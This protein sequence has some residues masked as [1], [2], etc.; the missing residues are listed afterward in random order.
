MN[1]TTRTMRWL[2]VCAAMWLAAESAYARGNAPPA[3]PA[4]K[5]RHENARKARTPEQVREA[6]HRRM[7]LIQDETKEQKAA[8]EAFEKRMKS[9]DASMLAAAKKKT[10]GQYRNM[11]NAF[12]KNR[13]RR[14]DEP[15][16]KHLHEYSWKKLQRRTE[17][18]K[19][20]DTNRNGKLT[21]A[22]MAKG[23]AQIQAELNQVISLHQDLKD[24]PPSA[25]QASVEKK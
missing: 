11:L 13:N 17:Y 25:Q 2:M 8:R 14:L 18:L 10:A 22:E 21:P 16:Q 1:T 23:K 7:G 12:D 20:W 9:P 19:Q 5:A 6:K 24:P 15:E 4:R 3:R